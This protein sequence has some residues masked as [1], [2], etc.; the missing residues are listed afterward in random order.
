MSSSK[1]S[2]FGSEQVLELKKTGELEG[3]NLNKLSLKKADL[4]NARLSKSQ[5]VKAKLKQAN[6][7]GADISGADLSKADLTG[8]DFSKADLSGANLSGVSA[9]KSNFDCANLSGAN[10]SGADLVKSTFKGGSLNGVD[11][12]K[13]AIS[14]C[15]FEGVD[16]GKADLSDTD[17]VNCSL[18]DVD[19]SGANVSDASFQNAIIEKTKAV[20]LN[21]LRS[22]FSLSRI[23]D[24]DFSQS[25]MSESD[26]AGTQLERVDFTGANLN[27]THFV[28]SE[29]KDVTLKDAKIEKASFKSVSG[30]SEDQIK[31]FAQRGA[32]VDLF[33][34]RRFLRML[35][36]S[37]VVQIA[38][39]V[40]LIGLGIYLYYFF[41][42]PSNWSS[43]K[44]EEK[45]RIEREKGNN[46][47]A[48]DLLTVLRKKFADF[49]VMQ[50]T[51]DILMAQTYVEMTQYANAEKLYKQ[52]MELAPETRFAV[53][54][55]LGLGDLFHRKGEL[56]SA[57][58]Y[59][60]MVATDHPE[61]PA[62]I[63][64]LNLY[65]SLQL[66]LGNEQEAVKVFE[67]FREKYPQNRDAL[68]NIEFSHAKFLN[69]KGRIVEALEKYRQLYETNSDFPARASQALQGILKIE[70]ETGKME[71]AEKTVILFKSH[72]AGEQGKEHF[73]HSAL[74]AEISLAHTYAGKG[75]FSKALPIYQQMMDNK[76][77][78]GP[79]Y[80]AGNSLFHHYSNQGQY[81]KAEQVL[82]KM[83]K[84]WGSDKKRGIE[85]KMRQ[86]ELMEAQGNPEEAMARLQKLLPNVEDPNTAYNGYT[87]MTERY[88]QIGNYTKAKE[89]IDLILNDPAM[90]KVINNHTYELLA[91][92]S[93]QQGDYDQALKMLEKA[94][95][96]IDE[97]AQVF[98]IMLARLT[99]YQKTN[100]LKNERAH[101]EKMLDLFK[102]D[103][104]RFSHVQMIQAD[105]FIRERQNKQAEA[106]LRQIADSP[107]QKEAIHGLSR[108]FRLYLNEGQIDKSMKIRDE[109]AK[110][111]PG[112]SSSDASA[113][114]AVAGML[115]E[116]SRVDE[117]LALYE[118]IS[119]TDPPEARSGALMSMLEIYRDTIQPQK[120]LALLPALQKG[121]KDNP[122]EYW[123]HMVLL[124]DGL[125]RPA[126]KWKEAEAIYGELIETNDVT[127]KAAQILLSM[128]MMRAEQGNQEEAGSL[129][130][131]L[132][133]QYS[134]YP[135][136]VVQAYMN[137]GG[138]EEGLGRREQALAHYV[139]AAE[140]A[141]DTN[142][143]IQAQG[144]MIR[145]LADSGNLQQAEAHFVEYQSLPGIVQEQIDLVEMAL[146]HAFRKNKDY[147]LATKRLNAIMVRSRNMGNW[148]NAARLVAE[149]Y[150]EQGELDAAL[151]QYQTIFEKLP[152]NDPMREEVELSL[153]FI[154]SR[155]EDYKSLFAKIKEMEARNIRRHTRRHINLQLGWALN[156]QGEKDQAD[157]VFRK[158]EQLSQDDWGAWY[159]ARQSRAG[160]Q[161]EKGNLKK[162]IDI[163]SETVEKIPDPDRKKNLMGWMAELYEKSGDKAKAENIRIQIQTQFQ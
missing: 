163:L 80:E 42:D 145:L 148:V 74:H 49:P 103:R 34:V 121:F 134:Q 90:Q 114:L 6:F 70:L 144:A 106:V 61:H 112:S 84:T 58:Q 59:Y 7:Q 115:R 137:L 97:K 113:S 24:T 132:L 128:A 142:S 32:K 72:L 47:K 64:A 79:A 82:A 66:E 126:K 33:L 2:T 30:Y 15:R 29:H 13:A 150:D 18:I 55:K 44:L 119:Q 158:V 9:A 67:D 155:I 118:K 146:I 138:F 151:K 3:A 37:H 111:F 48:L 26:F 130:Q 20:Q 108:L 122:T 46:Q 140:L 23:K 105:S 21:A 50:A 116:A 25:K 102:D 68:V 99:I 41:T 81:E 98:G 35:K 87:M 60:H 76:L 136:I 10:L 86:I 52:V 160:I 45:A 8:S 51:A 89:T 157:Q 161:V 125:L 104:A 110:R 4:S 143:K 17:A 71:A 154:Y 54:S 57:S 95:K 38:T 92:I 133:D 101:L 43:H 19:L 109:I 36:G 53:E 127:G 123:N 65:A 14:H 139:K 147:D 39:S 1:K 16:L 73:L 11:L 93:E 63:E 124:A 62:A 153:L 88:I 12:K 159:E 117:A 152:A 27:Q 131:R 85:V 96:G 78:P 107:T 135:R 31:A 83:E 94:E 91:R 100:N 129:Y 22:D 40:L 120:A 162:A 5:M 56:Q 77:D 28:V 75:E 141:A 156:K 69:E 149:I